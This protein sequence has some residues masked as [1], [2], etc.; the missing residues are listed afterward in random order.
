MSVIYRAK[1]VLPMTDAGVIENG[2]VW[3]EGD[4]IRD[5]GQGIAGLH[6]EVEVIDLGTAAILPGFVNVHSHIDPTFRRNFGDGLNLWDWLREL[7]FRR[8]G[9][10]SP[11]LLLASARLG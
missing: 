8:N 2:E 9:E 6:P 7:G 11:D 10:T 4:R 1:F 3:V 5:V